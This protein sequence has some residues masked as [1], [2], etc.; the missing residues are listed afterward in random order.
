MTPSYPP[1][2]IDVPNEKIGQPHITSAPSCEASSL[3]RA[4]SAS[5]MR[6]R[7]FVSARAALAESEASAA[8][9]IV[10]ATCSSTSLARELRLWTASVRASSA[11]RRPSLAQVRRASS[12]ELAFSSS[13]IFR[14]SVA[15]LA[16]KRSSYDWARSR[17]F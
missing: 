2:T 1:S 3:P 6:S 8:R 4:T 12:L 17:Y 5:N 9:C 7:C 14:A 13:A 11:R 15:C 16:L 10:G